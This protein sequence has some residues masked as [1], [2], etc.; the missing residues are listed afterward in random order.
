[1]LLFSFLLF[2]LSGINL[3][4]PWGQPRSDTDWDGVGGAQIIGNNITE[5]QPADLISI[6]NTKDICDDDFECKYMTIDEMY[7]RAGNNKFSILSQNV[8]S[9]GGKFDHL[10]EY[11][12]VK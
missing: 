8:P 5:G 12:T 2:F 7:G 9:L 1:M 11:V 10:K 4:L 3:N 6:L